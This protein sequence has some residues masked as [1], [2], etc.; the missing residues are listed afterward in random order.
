V[1]EYGESK[2]SLKSRGDPSLAQHLVWSQLLANLHGRARVNS[3]YGKDTSLAVLAQAR[4][5]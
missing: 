2:N 5:R 3:L 1:E 4:D